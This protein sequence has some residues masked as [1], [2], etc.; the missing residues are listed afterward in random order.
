MAIAN[1]AVS[2]LLE[3]EN[4]EGAGRAGNDVGSFL[5]AL[6]EAALLEEGSD[7]AERRNVR[8]CS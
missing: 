8:A 6:G 2:G 5:H 4:I 3:I 7:S 1:L